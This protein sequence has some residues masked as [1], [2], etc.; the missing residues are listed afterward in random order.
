MLSA[1]ERKRIDNEQEKNKLARE[2][3]NNDINA[4]GGTKHEQEIQKKS[5]KFVNKVILITVII[6]GI[7]FAVALF[8]LKQIG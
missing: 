7:V 8:I 3:D 6:L 1:S 2:E 5:A 4:Q